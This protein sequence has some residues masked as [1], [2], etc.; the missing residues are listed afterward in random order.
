MCSLNDNDSEIPSIS[1]VYIITDG[2]P[3]PVMTDGKQLF[4]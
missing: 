4:W 2:E 3:I 1:Y